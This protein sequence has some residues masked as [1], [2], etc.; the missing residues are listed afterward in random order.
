[1]TKRYSGKRATSVKEN[2][3]ERIKAQV[4]AQKREDPLARPPR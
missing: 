4:R 1:M 3:Y 2:H